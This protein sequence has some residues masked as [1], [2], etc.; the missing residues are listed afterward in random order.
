MADDAAPPGGVNF[1]DIHNSA[2]Q[3]G[4]IL[5]DVAPGAAFEARMYQR[6][7]RPYYSFSMLA[8]WRRI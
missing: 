8:C 1:A 3:T 5:V 6:L 2:I 7:A 4:P